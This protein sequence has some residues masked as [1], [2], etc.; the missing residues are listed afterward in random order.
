MKK[1][2]RIIAVISGIISILSF[3]VLGFMYAEKF[4]RYL[5]KKIGQTYKTSLHNDKYN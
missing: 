3:A 5:F 2:L 4:Y 1:M